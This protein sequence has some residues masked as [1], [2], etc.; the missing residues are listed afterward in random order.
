MQSNPQIGG[1][2][3]SAIVEA[4]SYWFLIDPTS[5]KMSCWPLTK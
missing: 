4:S 1:C 5:P 3:G 2:V